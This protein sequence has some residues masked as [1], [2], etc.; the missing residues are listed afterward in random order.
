MAKYLYNKIAN[1]IE[2]D[3]RQESNGHELLGL[4][5]S[6]SYFAE[7]TPSR[8]PFSKLLSIQ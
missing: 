8:L 3:T 4:F 7:W 6:P 5:V 1:L 2:I